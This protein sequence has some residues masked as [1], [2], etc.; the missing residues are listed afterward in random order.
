M[1]I[2]GAALTCVMHA[3]SV[4]HKK[5]DPVHPAIDAMEERINKNKGRWAQEIDT[6]LRDRMLARGSSGWYYIRLA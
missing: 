4:Y 3:R 6:L 2:Y 1:K 5:K